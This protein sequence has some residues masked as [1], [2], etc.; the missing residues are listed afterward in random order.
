M[1]RRDETPFWPK[2]DG[3]ARYFRPL[4]ARSSRGTRFG[5]DARLIRKR[6]EQRV[7]EWDAN[8]FRSP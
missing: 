4:R 6:D 5:D 3:L 2:R 1:D 8:A 7:E